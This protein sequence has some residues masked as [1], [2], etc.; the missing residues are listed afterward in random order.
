MQRAINAVEEMDRPDCDP[1]VAG[2]DLCPVPPGKQVRFRVARHL[3]V[4][5]LRLILRTPRFQR[6][7]HRAP[8]WTSGAAA[9]TSP[10][11][12]SGWA[13]ARGIEVRVVGID[14][15]ARAHDYAIRAAA[16]GRESRAPEHG[17]SRRIPPGAQ[18][19][20][21]GPGRNGSTWSSPTTCCT[22]WARWSWP[23]YSRIRRRWR[24]RSDTQRHPASR[25]ALLFFG[26]ATLPL[27]GP[28]SSAATASPRSAA[29]SPAPSWLPWHRR[30]G[31][32]GPGFR[33][34]TC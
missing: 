30:A 29:A 31:R 2:T 33:S 27:A 8:S 17:R 1:A 5:V 24:A 28:P 32:S 14:P 6:Q 13:R 10:G 25:T 3:A 21:G 20:P 22:T 16:E 23:G 15:D 19:R 7:P 4:Y 12:C 26:L 9:G 11:T 34:G 18:L